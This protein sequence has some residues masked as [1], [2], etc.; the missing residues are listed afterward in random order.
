M[1]RTIQTIKKSSPKCLNNAEAEKAYHK[2]SHMVNLHH[3]T[4][5]FYLAYLQA[6]PKAITKNLTLLN[7]VILNNLYKK[8]KNLRTIVIDMFTP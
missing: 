1:N 2:E 3:I 8:I 6:L 7:E 4:N 5:T